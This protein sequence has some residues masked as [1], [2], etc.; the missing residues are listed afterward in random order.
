MNPGGQGLCL[1]SGRVRNRLPFA[2]LLPS[3]SRRTVCSFSGHRGSRGGEP[4]GVWELR[5]ILRAELGKRLQPFCHSG[6]AAAILAAVEGG[7]QP[8]G[9]NSSGAA[10]PYHSRVGLAC[11]A[12]VKSAAPWA[13]L[14]GY[15]RRERRPS[16][17]AGSPALRQA[18]RLPLPVAAAILAARE[19]DILPPG[20]SGVGAVT[21][22]LA[23][24][25][26]HSLSSR[27]A[28]LEARSQRQAGRLPLPV[29]AA[30]LAAVEGGILPL[31]QG[32]QP[33]RT[34]RTQSVLLEGAAFP[35]RPWSDRADPRRKP[36]RARR[37]LR[38]L[39]PWCT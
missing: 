32:G 27:T 13:A 4:H 8:P 6:V 17:R 34:G 9:K 2:F 5:P 10:A 29:A 19:G 15:G 7:F 28:G 24:P 14:T 21:P 38:F 30:I 33:P 36:F 23:L 31:G 26:L 16:R 20:K 1:D 22:N 11:I 37:I 35:L 12:A 3:R 25:R 18:G 39:F